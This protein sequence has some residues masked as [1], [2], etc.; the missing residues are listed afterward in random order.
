MDAIRILCATDD[1]YV[2]YTGVML[3]SLFESNKHETFEVFILT[4]GINRENANKLQSLAI[5]YQNEIHIQEVNP[6]MFSGCPIRPGDHVTLET[7]FRL[8]TPELLPERIERILY[9]DVDMVINGPVRALWDWNIDRY[10]VGAVRDESFCKQEFYT[11]LGL[12][13]SN[14]YFNAGVLLLNLKYWRERDVSGRCMKCIAE[15]PDILKF[16]DQDTLNIVLKDEKV[17]LPITYNFQT[18]YY[19]SWVYPD[20]PADFKE[21]V[22]KTA[23]NPIVIHYSGPMKPWM[24]S[25]G[26]QPYRHFYFYYRMLSP[27][28][29]FPLV[30]DASLLD[31]GRLLLGR[32]AKSVGLLPKKYVI[33]TVRRRGGIK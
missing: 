2:P 14:P 25:C 8:L 4:R 1:N 27:W 16:H 33:N 24:L 11:R 32:F 9:L 20:Y 22:H 10:A 28:K 5:L 30:D 23:P 31:R 17:L 7:Y 13:S 12:D 6:A 18:G 29:A 21:Q 3:T 19:L 26:D 15:N